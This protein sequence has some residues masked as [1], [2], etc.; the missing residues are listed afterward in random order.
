MARPINISLV[1]ISSYDRSEQMLVNNVGTNIRKPTAEY[2]SEEYSKIMFS[3]LYICVPRVRFIR[4]KSSKNKSEI[5]HS[6]D[7]VL[8]VP[9]DSLEP[10]SEDI[11]ETKMLL[12]KLVVVKFDGASGTNMGFGC[13]KSA[14]E[15]HDG[16]TFLDL[17]INQIESL[18]SKYGCKVPLILMDTNETNDDIQK[19]LEKYSGSKIDIHSFS[20]TQ[21][22]QPKLFEGQSGKELYPSDHGAM[23][24]SLIKGGTLDVLLSQGKEY[25]LVVNSDNAAAVVDLKILDHLIENNIEYCMEETPTTSTNLRNSTINSM[26]QKFQ[27][28]VISLCSDSGTKSCKFAASADRI[29]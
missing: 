3:G 12:D 13:P 23:F 16:L 15:I 26:Q 2:S 1:N 22:P 8:V 19:V 29:I 4:G 20:Q 28:S 10:I 14:I 18:N 6:N 25:V 24:L 9:Y 17:I 5:D 27:V 11:S 21:Q 7:K